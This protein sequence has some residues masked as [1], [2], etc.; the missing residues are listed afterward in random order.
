MSQPAPLLDEAD[1]LRVASIERYDV[2]AG[3]RRV[4]LE[5]IAELA[6]LVCST[7]MATVNLITDVAQHQVA[8]HG[9]DASICSRE[10][11]MCA[12][13]L[14]RPR[15]V[16]VPDARLDPRFRDNPFVTGVI[17]SVRFYAS[18]HLVTPEG[19]V[20]GTLCVFDEEPRQITERQTHALRTLA[21]RVVDVLELSLRSRE[22][23]TTNERLSEFAGRVSH[24]LKAPL[25]TVVL[26]LETVIDLLD[27]GVDPATVSG[28]LQRAVGGTRRM[29]TMIDDVLAFS[30]AGRTHRQ[31]AR[32]PRHGAR[33]RRG[34]PRGRLRAGRHP[35]ARPLPVVWGDPVLLRSVLQ[36]FLDNA[37]KYR[38]PGRPLHV[39]VRAERRDEAW[40]RVCVADDGPGVPVEDRSGSSSAASGSTT[41]TAAPAS[42]STPAGTRSRPT[43]DASGST[44]PRAGVRRSGSRCP[45]RRPGSS[46]RGAQSRWVLPGRSSIRCSA[47][48]ASRS[49]SGS[50]SIRFTTTPSTS[51]S[52][53]HTKCGRSMRFIVEQ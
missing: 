45:P 25:T 29:A 22:L 2:L 9:F 17:G 1:A 28:V 49:V 19:V 41:T 5:A 13:T 40:W 47:T 3:P 31:A 53:A 34:R 39:V 10:D 50:T 44:R 16:V 4:D 42:G 46:C 6:A 51:D 7:P 23:A 43:A 27:D 11:S 15:P 21:D 32:R 24:D 26:A 20:I 8:T 14:E 18:T 30:S 48:R 12:R 35:R 36:N 33:R 52:I 38:A 37:A